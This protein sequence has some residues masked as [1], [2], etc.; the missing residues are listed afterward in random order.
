MKDFAAALASGRVLFDGGMGALLAAMNIKTE[1]PEE[2]GHEQPDLI[3]G[4]HAAYRQAGSQ[5]VITNSLGIHPVKLGKTGRA[6][7]CE[8]WTRSAVNNA[9]NSGEGFVALDIGTTGE[10]LQP[11]G[12]MSFDTAFDGFEKVCA[13]GK[14]AGAD[15]AL[16]ETMTDIA[17]CRCACLAAHKAG[18]PAAASFTFEKNGRTLTGGTP[19]CAAL[20]LSSVG[21]VALGINCSG[22]AEA[23][24]APLSAMRAVTSLPIIVQPNAGLPVTDAD[25]NTYY[26]DSP[27]TMLPHMQTIL[28]MGAAAIGGCCGTTPDHIRAF[29]ALDLSAPAVS[30]WDGI[31]RICSQRAWMDASEALDAA[32]RTADIDDLYDLEEEECAL[33]PLGEVDDIPAFLQEAQMATYRPLIFES[34][35]AEA[36]ETA[37]RLYPGVAGVV[38]TLDMPLPYG[39]VRM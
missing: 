39:A 14:E 22:G 9:V 18:L 6:S 36:L 5:V 19:E 20:I 28:D 7:H 27:E 37:L 10:F 35:D 12:S 11:V 30:A 38:T 23:M 26:P 1:C 32:V 29:A 15:F 17:E 24:F 34:D 16:L 3:R 8:E 31:T 21:A 25:G 13:A 2:L 4:I 33:I